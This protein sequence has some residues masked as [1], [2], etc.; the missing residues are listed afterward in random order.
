MGDLPGHGKQNRCLCYLM[1]QSHAEYKAHLPCSE[2]HH[3]FHDYA[4]ISWSHPPNV[5]GRAC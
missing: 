4:E 3:L 5:K 1:L 2:H